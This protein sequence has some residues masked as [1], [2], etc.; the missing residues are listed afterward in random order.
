MYN[1]YTHKTF[2][3][4]IGAFLD[5][6][7]KYELVLHLVEDDH[8]PDGAPP[9]PVGLE[10]DGRKMCQKHHVNNFSNSLSHPH[11]FHI[12]VS[13]GAGSLV[14]VHLISPEPSDV[15]KLLKLK[16]KLGCVR[17]TNQNFWL[18]GSRASPATLLLKV[19]MD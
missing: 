10:P 7:G 16:I 4:E 3:V 12:A 8:P 1:T 19:R 2:S 18:D 6:L 9:P 13:R 15:E 17:L 11:G 14:T 5:E